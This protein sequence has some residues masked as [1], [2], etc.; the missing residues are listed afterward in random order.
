MAEHGGFWKDIAV[1]GGLRCATVLLGLAALATVAVSFVE[2]VK[3][4]CRARLPAADAG[5]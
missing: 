1:L 2:T 4:A 5:G 3:S